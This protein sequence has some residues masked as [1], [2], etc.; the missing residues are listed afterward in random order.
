MRELQF[1]KEFDLISV[2]LF[3]IIT[4]SK[5][6]H[7][8]NNPSL[9]IFIF[10]GNIIFL[11]DMHPEKAYFPITVSLFGIIISVRAVQSEKA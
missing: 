11:S 4:D 7:S 8:L 2:T 9:I 5:E 10:E 6:I 3:G 1:E